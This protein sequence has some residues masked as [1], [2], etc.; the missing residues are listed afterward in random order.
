MDTVRQKGRRPDRFA[1]V[2]KVGAFQS[3]T[4]TPEQLA[5]INEHTTRPYAAEELFVFRTHLANDQYDRAYERFSGETL[6]SFA[7]TIIGR[8]TLKGHDY[9]TLPIATVFDAGVVTE[10]GTKWLVTW[11]Y[12]P[13][14]ADNEGDRERMEAGVYKYASIGFSGPDNP[15]LDPD[16]PK[17]TLT[18]NICGLDYYDGCPHWGGEVYEVG[19]EDGNA[20]NKERV[21]GSFTFTGPGNAVEQSIVYLGCQFGAELKHADP[22]QGELPPEMLERRAE[23]MAV[24]H[25][26]AFAK[27]YDGLLQPREKRAEV[28]AEPPAATEAGDPLAEA[29]DVWK[30]AAAV[31]QKAG[32]ALSKANENKLRAALDQIT[33]GAVII[34][35]VLSAVT[36]APPADDDEEQ[37]AAPAPEENGAD[38]EPEPLA[39][40]EQKSEIPNPE[41]EAAPAVRPYD[42]KHVTDLVE[43]LVARNCQTIV[44]N[45]AAQL[46][47]ERDTE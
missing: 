1:K 20:A 35:D 7:Q 30:R 28:A 24:A 47:A 23:G 32:R 42:P 12:M 31:A 14:T 17:L 9:S 19:G 4:P 41:A 40:P 6:K 37:Q 10:G 34:E 26:A 44:A 21:V 5:K 3:G 8:G 25:A 16:A 39:D 13:K 11:A 27:S 15:T 2:F 43:E 36:E 45:L 38:P 18:C 46:T 33:S 29:E 22:P